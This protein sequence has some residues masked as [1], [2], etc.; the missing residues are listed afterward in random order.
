MFLLLN[1]LSTAMLTGLI[2]TIQIVHY[3]SFRFI[4]RG[5]FTNYEAFHVRRMTFVV[6]PMML[7]E[8]A[9]SLILFFQNQSLLESLNLL[10]LV[11]VWGVTFFISVPLHNK[12]GHSFDEKALD[13]LILT[14][15]PRTILWSAKSVFSALLLIAS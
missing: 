12:L 9:M 2:W 5:Q 13:A 4:E 14:N 1:L 10:C 11:G 7:L 6:M 8:A 3:P 15:W